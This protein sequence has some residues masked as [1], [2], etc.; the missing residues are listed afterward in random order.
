MSERQR[1]LWLDALKGIGILAIMRIHMLAPIES[2]ESVIYVGAVAMFFIIAGFNLRVGTG[3]GRSISK[4][5]KRLLIPYFF[6]SFML[7]VAETLSNGFEWRYLLGIFYAR[8][9]LFAASY[10]GGQNVTF[11][12]IGNGPMW[13]LVC[14]FVAFL[15]IYT[16]YARCKCVRSKLLVG[17]CF[18][19][20]SV[21]L[22]Y[23]PM[24]LPW[25]IDTSFVC[26]LLMVFGYEFKHYFLNFKVQ[27]GLLAL[28]I[29]LLLYC[30]FAGSNLSIG[31]YGT[32]SWS[33]IPFILIA[34][35]ETYAL[36]YMLKIVEYTYLSKVLAYLGRHS[37]RLM[38]IHLFVYYKAIGLVGRF[39]P[40]YSEN[41]LV[42]IPIS[43]LL[44]LSCDAIV[45]LIL[46][47]F[48]S[49]IQLFKYL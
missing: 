39:L 38:C 11:L 35:S 47:R 21:L 23:S 18:L 26:A 22:G 33:I 46:C 8:M 49:R 9:Q 42:V 19:A 5:A 29:W 24:M 15:W 45:E 17:I 40:E 28:C 25:S 20:L 48:K 36:S 31:V 4:K 44:I 7:L 6:Y 13:F 41:R 3:D 1:I 2:V 30:F 27:R 37:L 43:F 14:M 10:M 34:I 32:C 16:I 12:V